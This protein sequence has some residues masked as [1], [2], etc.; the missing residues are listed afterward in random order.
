MIEFIL[1]V[2][3]LEINSSKNAFVNFKKTL[4]FFVFVIFD[5][6]NKPLRASFVKFKLSCYKLLLLSWLSQHLVFLCFFKF[7]KLCLKLNR[8]L[9]DGKFF[10]ICWL[11]SGLVLNF[12]KNFKNV[13]KFSLESRFSITSIHVFVIFLSNLSWKI[14]LLS[15]KMFSAKMWRRLRIIGSILIR[16]D[17]PS[18]TNLLRHILGLLF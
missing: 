11:I 5:N 18:S 9:L 2:W 4:D 8:E 16:W 10:L 14:S 17:T 6:V 13:F 12:L 15:W 7:Q 3:K 1:I